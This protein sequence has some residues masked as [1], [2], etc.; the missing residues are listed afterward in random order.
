MSRLSF[1]ARGFS[2]LPGRTAAT[3]AAMRFHGST[4]AIA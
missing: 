2:R 4:F 1:Q 3:S